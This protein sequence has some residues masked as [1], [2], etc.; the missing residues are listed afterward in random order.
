MTTNGDWV[1]GFMR[2]SGKRRSPIAS[3]DETDYPRINYQGSGGKTIYWRELNGSDPVV[4]AMV[5]NSDLSEGSR[6]FV[7]GRRE[8]IFT[9][10]ATDSEGGIVQ[11]VFLYNTDAGTLEQLTSDSGAKLGGF[12]WR[13]PE[14]NN[15]YVF[16]TTVDRTKLRVYRKIDADGDGSME[17]TAIN[18]ILPPA[19]IPYIW[20][21]EPFVYNGRSYLFMQLSSSTL[22]NDMSVP[23]QIGLTGIDPQQPKLPHAH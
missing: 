5:P 7:E 8:I 21:P 10:G 6:R 11:Q 13:A 16:F 2:L 20:S 14:F 9:A 1:G 15:E 3:L 17:W 22:A 19:S 12:M 18:T 4:E 23:T